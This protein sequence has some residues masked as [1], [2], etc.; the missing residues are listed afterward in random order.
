MGCC[1]STAPAAQKLSSGLQVMGV[2]VQNNEYVRTLG[3]L[4]IPSQTAPAG[5]PLLLWLQGGK[6]RSLLRSKGKELKGKQQ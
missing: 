5:D 2:G 1:K 3:H 6:M 4:Y